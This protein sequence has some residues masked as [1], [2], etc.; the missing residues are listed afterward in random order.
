MRSRVQNERDVNVASKH[1]QGTYPER[2]VAGFGGFMTFVIIMELA[3][4][5]DDDDDDGRE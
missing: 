3:D 2:A 4:D 5:D 1:R